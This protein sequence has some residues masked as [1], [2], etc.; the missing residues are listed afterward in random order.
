MFKSHM[1]SYY[2]LCN[3]ETDWGLPLQPWD[4]HRAYEIVKGNNKSATDFISVGTHSM[5]GCLD[6]NGDATEA[7]ASDSEMPA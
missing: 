6:V 5:F 4:L 3:Q 7:S 1:W 2:T